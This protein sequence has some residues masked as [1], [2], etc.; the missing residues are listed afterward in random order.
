[1]LQITKKNYDTAHH[2]PSNKM[3]NKNSHL[4]LK[5]ALIFSGDINLNPGPVTAH[6]IK[7]RKFEV[8]KT[9]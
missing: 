4:H 2:Q 1:M 8:F 7:D 9:K 3:K 6:Q 5:M